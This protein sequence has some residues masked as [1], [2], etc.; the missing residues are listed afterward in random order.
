MGATALVLVIPLAAAAEDRVWLGVVAG[1]DWGEVSQPVS[2]SVLDPRS[3]P[4]DLFR[5]R[6]TPLAQATMTIR[7]N[8]KLDLSFEAGWVG[9]GAKDIN[10]HAG[11]PL[12]GGRRAG[13]ALARRCPSRR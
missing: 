6:L 2:G 3:A 5:P 10:S 11:G 1:A 4:I 9:K 7:L 8:S 12:S 13:Q